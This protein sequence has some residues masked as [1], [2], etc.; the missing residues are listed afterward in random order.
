MLCEGWTKGRRP[1][2]HIQLKRYHIFPKIFSKN[3]L[4][5]TNETYLFWAVASEKSLP[6]HKN[7][8]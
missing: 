8:A 3:I 1:A 2:E 5:G 7:T 4:H 6:L